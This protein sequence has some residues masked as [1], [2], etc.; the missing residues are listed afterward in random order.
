MKRY[1]H[2][3]TLHLPWS[4][5]LGK[6][7]VVHSPEF[8]FQDEVVVTEKLDGECT[9]IYPDGSF[10]ARSLDSKYHNPTQWIVRQIAEHLTIHP[11]I[12]PE[13]WR[14]V[15]ENLQIQH[16]ISYDKLPAFFLVFNVYNE[17][18]VC[19][20]WDYTV[21]LVR[22]L[23]TSTDPNLRIFHVP[24][25]YVGPWNEKEI[26]SCFTGVS[27]YGGK[28]EGY[29]V[30]KMNAFPYEE[31]SASTAKFVRKEHVQTEQHW[32]QGPFVQNKMRSC[33]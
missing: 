4:E 23:D 20:D 11:N 16:S 28:Q 24:E 15:G 8:C 29:V 30:R 12:F 7:D 27:H 25:L 3:K 19:L 26:K 31:Y 17:E 1:K 10:H 21:R 9:T 14:I 2:P 22:L 6:G 18:N 5:G 33:H 32:R 13:G